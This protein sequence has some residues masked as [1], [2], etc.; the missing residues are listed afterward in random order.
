MKRRDEASAPLIGDRVAYVF[1]KKNKDS[2]GFEKAEDPLY[3]LENNLPLDFE[4]Y[5]NQ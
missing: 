3:A 5:L 2:K 1:I 4:H